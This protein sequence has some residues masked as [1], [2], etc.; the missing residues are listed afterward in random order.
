MYIYIYV[1]KHTYIYIHIYIYIYI[2]ITAVLP[3]YHRT[4]YSAQ[5]VPAQNIR[6]DRT[7]RWLD[8]CLSMRSY[9][10]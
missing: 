5:R 6:N 2:Y 7:L 4:V 1:N 10:H 8:G 9:I 3:I